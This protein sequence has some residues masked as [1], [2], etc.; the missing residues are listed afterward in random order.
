MAATST[1]EASR[2]C[3]SFAKVLRPRTT[4]AHAVS[5]APFTKLI[6]NQNRSIDT[7]GFDITGVVTTLELS[8]PD[9]KNV[10]DCIQECL[11]R[12][13]TCA[14]YV[15]DFH[16]ADAIK[17]GHRTCILYSNFNLPSDVTVVFAPDDPQNMN[18]QTL[19]D[20]P[21]AGGPVPQAFTD[22]QGTVPDDGAFSG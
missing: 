1:L 19:E 22:D 12:P 17:S 14:N 11:N 9:V 18:I 21:Q 2:K 15:F 4:G 16:D 6:A 10:C 3:P 7:Q 20:N 5:S 8:F 13:G